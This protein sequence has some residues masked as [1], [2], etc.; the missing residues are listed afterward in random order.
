[1]L[2]QLDAFLQKNEIHE[3]FQSGFRRGHSTETALI[4][5]T[6]DLRV[7]ADNKNFSVLVLLDLSS[8]GLHSRP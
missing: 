7:S 2:K 3:K 8:H 6:N 4:K 1:M 5:V